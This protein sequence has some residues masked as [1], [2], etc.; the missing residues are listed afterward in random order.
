MGKFNKTFWLILTLT[1]LAL[2][3]VSFLIIK[4]LVVNILAKYHKLQATNKELDSV[5]QEKDILTRYNRTKNEIDSL[6]NMVLTFLPEDKDSGDFVVQIDKIAS[7]TNQNQTEITVKDGTK[8]QTADQDTNSTNAK[9]SSTA[10]TKQTQN[11]TVQELNFTITQNG[12]FTDLTG[13]LK[14]LEKASRLNSLKTIKITKQLDDSLVTSIEGSIY[15]KPNLTILDIVTNL[16][17]STSDKINI[18][19]LEHFGDIINS[20]PNQTGKQDPF[21]PL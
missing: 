19:S 8:T 7:Q 13:F 17:I 2:I 10:S 15:Y 9:T 18:N 11:I 16:E 20:S 5:N 12:S 14:N 3:V 4:P 6:N 21:S 1:L